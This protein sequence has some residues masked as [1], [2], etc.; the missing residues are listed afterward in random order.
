MELIKPYDNTTD[1]RDF[2]KEFKIA[3]VK[4]KWNMPDQ[5]QLLGVN[6]N[7][8]AKDTFKSIQ[9]DD[10]DIYFSALINKHSKSA[11]EY[12]NEFHKVEP[13]N[14]ESPTNFAYR[15]KKLFNRAFISMDEGAKEVLLKDKFISCLPEKLRNVVSYSS[16]IQS[17]EKV[18]EGVEASMPKFDT[19]KPLELVDLNYNKVQTQRNIQSNKN[20]SC[21]YCNKPNHTVDY[22]R[23]KIKHDQER[24]QTYQHKPN[25]NYKNRNNYHNNYNNNRNQRSYS[26]SYHNSKTNSSK[27]EPDYREQYDNRPFKRNKYNQQNEFET[28]TTSVNND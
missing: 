6:L 18:V 9:S 25:I 20:I 12:L 1:I 22:C 17:F 10:I 27:F 24:T 16:K 21:S 19:V 5:I 28:N 14:N 11:A 13:S 26:N 8:F 23:L 3:A 4:A 15:L 7:G 2:I